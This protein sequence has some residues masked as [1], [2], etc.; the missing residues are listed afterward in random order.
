MYNE[1]QIKQF[2]GLVDLHVESMALV[3]L[4]AGPNSV[5]KTALL[6]ALWIHNAPNQPNTSL[7]VNRF[8]GLDNFDPNKLLWELFPDLNA[9]VQIELSA[10]GDWGPGTRVLKIHLEDRGTVDTPLRRDGDQE[11]IGGGESSSRASR[12]QIVYEYKSES[13]IESTSRGYFVSSVVGAGIIEES[14]RSE[15]ES[16][17]R[18]ER[19]TFMAARHRGG[20]QEEVTRLSNI[21][22]KK[23]HDEIV[24]TLQCIDPRGRKTE[25][26]WRSQK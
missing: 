19:G 14:F 13:G 18:Q 3:N 24:E 16:I 15:I 12:E 5:G 25:S 8:R 17:G 6:E 9:E 22:E 11:E 20:Q 2:R 7:R 4:I 23:R 26:Y 1:I 10:K 21:L